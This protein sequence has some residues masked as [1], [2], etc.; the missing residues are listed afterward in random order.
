MKYATVLMLYGC[1]DS[2]KK[3]WREGGFER[4]F[5]YSYTG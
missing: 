3:S 2:S 1:D 5:I 4:H